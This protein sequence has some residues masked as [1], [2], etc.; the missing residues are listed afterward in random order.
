MRRMIVRVAAASCL[1]ALVGAMATTSM[2]TGNAGAATQA[3][4]ATLPETL[5]EAGD[6]KTLVALLQA[7]GLDKV[8]AEGGPFTVFAP[9]DE[10]FAKVPAETLAALAADPGLL[11]SVLLYHVVG[12]N[13]PSSVATTLSSAT[14]VGGAKIGLSV[15]GESLYVNNAKVVKADVA[16]SN[17]VAHVIDTVLIPPTEPSGGMNR[18]GYCAVTGNTTPA[19]EPIRAGLFLELKLGQPGW[20]YHYAGAVPANYVEGMG[21]TCS[22]PPAGYT[23][24]GTAPESLGVPG[25]VYP[26]YVKG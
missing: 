3:S 4:A 11:T 24:Q 17:G 1:V 2:G 13:V 9:S 15:V 12:G 10:A 21:I 26:Y 23:L 14:T 22:A 6:F 16:A 8:L 7:T 18:A 25:G 5:V 19:G 20:D